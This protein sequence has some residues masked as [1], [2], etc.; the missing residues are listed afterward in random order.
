MRG[1]KCFYDHGSDP[2]VIKN[3]SL[4]DV[5]Y[6]SSAVLASP[7]SREPYVDHSAKEMIEGILNNIN[8]I[9]PIFYV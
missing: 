9:M 3:T 4:N 2:V 7:T 8:L 1:D 6:N 5:V